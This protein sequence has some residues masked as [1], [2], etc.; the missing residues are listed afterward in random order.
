MGRM[1]RGSAVCSLP[2]IGLMN[3]NLISPLPSK[4]FAPPSLSFFL[5]LY[6]EPFVGGTSD[7]QEEG[8]KKRELREELS[9]R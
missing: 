7:F 8:R 3:I 9:G 4:T 2:F 6:K 1:G 5:I